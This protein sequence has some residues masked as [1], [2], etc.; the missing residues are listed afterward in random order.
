MATDQQSSRSCKSSS[1]LGI[2]TDLYCF[3]IEKDLHLLPLD[4]SDDDSISF[5]N[6]LG[7]PCTST[8]NSSFHDS[9]GTSLPVEPP[10][11][12]VTYDISSNIDTPVIT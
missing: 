6:G 9:F 7:G 4:T 8:P 11:A 10:L 2:V 1:V 5:I 12:N 3:S